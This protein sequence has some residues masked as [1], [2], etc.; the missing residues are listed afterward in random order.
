MF[1]TLFVKVFNTLNHQLTV[2]VN[3]KN[4]P[5]PLL[6]LVISYAI[7]MS[8]SLMDVRKFYARYLCFILTL[9]SM[10]FFTSA[11]SFFAR[12]LS[13]LSNIAASLI[14]NVKF[15]FDISFTDLYDRSRDRE[16]KA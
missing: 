1:M 10:K 16:R 3:Y 14:F 8:Q 6:R 13:R 2:P 12:L 9:V 15:S 7:D 5:K 4:T 11:C